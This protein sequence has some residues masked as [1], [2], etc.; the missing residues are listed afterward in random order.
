M[1]KLLIALLAAAGIVAAHS[2]DVGVLAGGGGFTAS[3]PT[4]ATGAGHWE[5]WWW[6]VACGS[7]FAITGTSAPKFESTG[8]LRTRWKG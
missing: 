8:C 6:A 1:L 5:A 3:G 2:T 4:L 7:R